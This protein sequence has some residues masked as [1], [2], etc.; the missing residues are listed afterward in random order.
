MANGRGCFSSKDSSLKN[1][2]SSVGATAPLSAPRPSLLF[3][4]WRSRGGEHWRGKKKVK[5]KDCTTYAAVLSRVRWKRGAGTVPFNIYKAG[6]IYFLSEN[7]EIVCMWKT[8]VISESI[9]CEW[10]CLIL[11]CDGVMNDERV[12]L[13]RINILLPWQSLPPSSVCL[14][15]MHVAD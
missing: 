6:P 12:N 2:S 5:K 14:C 13:G 8:K 4:V 3:F 10:K 11:G 7:V 1:I 15:N 9:L